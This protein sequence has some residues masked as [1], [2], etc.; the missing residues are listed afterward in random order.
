MTFSF[1]EELSN[2]D[3]EEFLP[4]NLTPKM[5]AYIG[6]RVDDF[7][8]QYASKENKKIRFDPDIMD[9]VT[10]IYVSQNGD[11]EIDLS[12]IN[13]IIAYQED[14]AKGATYYCLAVHRE[15]LGR[16]SGIPYEN[17]TLENILTK[18][19]DSYECNEMIEKVKKKNCSGCSGC[20]V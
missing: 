2:A 1:K 5:L 9:I 14:M 18:A 10:Q 17:P 15:A 6:I 13:N 3:A 11:H 20:S 7:I 12:D 4:Q 19:P 8:E 16:D